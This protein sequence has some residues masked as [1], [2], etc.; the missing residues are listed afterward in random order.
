MPHFRQPKVV[1]PANT[2]D[3]LHDQ[4]RGAPEA[5][6]APEEAE[7]L[8]E[9]HREGRHGKKPTRLR[10]GKLNLHDHEPAFSDITR[11]LFGKDANVE[12]QS[13]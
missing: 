5:R 7:T 13:G 9:L 6:A 12:H 1:K 11:A 2:L 10:P 4:P 3:E 8:D